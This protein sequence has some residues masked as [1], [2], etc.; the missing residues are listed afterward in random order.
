VLR[1][2]SLQQFADVLV[3]VNDEDVIGLLH[4]S[5]RSSPLGE[6]MAD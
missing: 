3:I 2:V 4:A 6:R 5:R 1:E